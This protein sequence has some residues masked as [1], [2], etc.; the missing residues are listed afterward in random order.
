M[1]MHLHMKENMRIRYLRPSW[2]PALCA[3]VL[4]SILGEKAF[5]QEPATQHAGAVTPLA[6]LLQ[7]AE[8]SN[9]QIEAARQ[10]WQAA[11]QVPTQVSTRPD[12]QF[13]LQHLNVG[14]P[15]PFA[16]YTNS[17]FAYIGLGVSQDFPYPGKLRLRGEVA[18]RE[19][20][21]MQQRYESVR[22]SVLVGI[23]SAY[24]HLSYLSKTVA[25]LQSDGELLRQVEQSADAHYRS[26]M[27]NQQ[28]LLQ[29]QL[30]RT[31]LLREITMRHL[32][33]AKL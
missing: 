5:A 29:A 1:K 33:V 22:R 6:E 31:K 14:S 30:E 3:L 17:D 10:G 7:E 21:V 2:A 25:I 20:D 12:P 26:G 15:R 32:G 24:F 8:K 19:A 13:V 9:P 18:K 23:K 28:E 11:K 27:G 16:G 4:V